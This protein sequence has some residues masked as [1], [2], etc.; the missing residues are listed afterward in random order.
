METEKRYNKQTYRLYL[1]SAWWTQRRKL[2]WD[3]H[4]RKCT[5]C[6]AFAL[7]LHHKTYINI[8]NE[9]DED[10][11]ALCRAC[12]DQ[13]HYEYELKKKNKK[14]KIKDNKF[15]VAHPKKKKKKNNPTLSRK[16]IIELKEQYKDHPTLMVTKKGK[17]ISKPINKREIR[18]AK[19]KEFAGV[20]IT[21]G[22]YKAFN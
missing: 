6:G 8:N 5:V 7:D 3:N 18:R 4:K 15:L 16:T 20:L 17:I 11:M 10:L 14:I 22:N 2:Y 13:I 12:H 1:K 19:N 9:K 21:K